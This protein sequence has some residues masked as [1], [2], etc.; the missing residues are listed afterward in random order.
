[1]K[2]MK[3]L[4]ILIIAI[5]VIIWSAF[6]SIELFE[7]F[8]LAFFP[9]TMVLVF[10]LTYRKFQFTTFTYWMVLLH[11]IIL[12]IGAKYTYSENP[13]FNYLQEVFDLSRNHYDRV[14]HLAQGFFPVFLARE[15]LVR[16]QYIRKS[17][18]FYFIMYCIILAV[19]AF[20]ELLEFATTVVLGLPDDY[21]LSSQ[22]DIWDSEWDMVM[23]LIGATLSLLLFDKYHNRLLQSLQDKPIE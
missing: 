1:M 16:N 17:K 21:V 13:L 8:G 6:T 14:G 15:I 18:F 23:A 22:G 2:S 5:I 19:S 3:H 20:Y 7:Y 11:I 4:I 9:V 10:L 12:L